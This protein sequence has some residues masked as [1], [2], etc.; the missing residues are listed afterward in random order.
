MKNNT[1]QSLFL[2]NP[3][4]WTIWKSGKVVRSG[5]GFQALTSLAPGQSKSYKW[6]NVGQLVGTGSYLVRVGPIHRPNGTTFFVSRTIAIAAGGKIA[7]TNRFPLAAGNVWQYVA[8]GADQ[9][10][11]IKVG[12]TWGNV[13]SIQG[14]L[15]KTFVVQ[16]SQYKTLFTFHRPLGFSYS[17]ALDPIQGAM[18]KVGSTKDTLETPAGK[19]TNLYRLDVSY[20]PFGLVQTV[21]NSFWFAPG[22]GLVG[23]DRTH[24]AGPLKFRLESLNI[25]GSD[26]KWYFVGTDK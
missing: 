2:S 22:I 26:G 8:A 25:R 13:H 21:Y 5:I 6:D 11:T 9:K 17:V 14:L 19:F 1:A 7:G 12:S 20:G 18:L 16:G 15:D 4:P 3:T 23:F 10:S 24:P